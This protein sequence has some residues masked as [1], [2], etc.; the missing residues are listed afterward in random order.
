[1]L[2]STFL[3]VSVCVHA[4]GA[5]VSCRELVGISPS[6]CRVILRRGFDEKCTSSMLYVLVLR[7][8]SPIV[9]SWYW[10]DRDLALR[11]PGA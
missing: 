10:Q 2:A 1:M 11:W 3:L 7:W 4:R 9:S 8:R 5:R 6:F